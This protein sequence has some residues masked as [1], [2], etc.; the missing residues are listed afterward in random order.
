MATLTSRATGPG[1]ASQIARASTTLS[2]LSTLRTPLRNSPELIC[3]RWYW[4]KRS[5]NTAS[6][7]ALVAMIIQIIHPPWDKKLGNMPFLYDSPSA[8]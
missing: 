3:S 2:R 5:R 6:A 7:T 1:V 4:S 8:D